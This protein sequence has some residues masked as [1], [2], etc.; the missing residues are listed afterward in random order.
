MQKMRIYLT[1]KLMNRTV[2]KDKKQSKSKKQILKNRMNQL[3]KARP[4]RK[5]FKSKRIQWKRK[6]N[7][8]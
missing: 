5:T 3:T 6:K 2:L 8:L 7:K 4:T 1:L